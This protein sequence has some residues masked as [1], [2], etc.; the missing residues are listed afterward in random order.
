MSAKEIDRKLSV[1]SDKTGIS[2]AA[3]VRLCVSRAIE[4]VSNDIL[5]R[6]P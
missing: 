2:K 5:K 6:K 1:L 3:I 4:D